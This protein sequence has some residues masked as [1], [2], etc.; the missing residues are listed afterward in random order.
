MGVE[1]AGDAGDAGRKKN[2]EILRAYF[3]PGAPRG[4]S[5]KNTDSATF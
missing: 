5:S 4:R 3:N 1:P 2:L